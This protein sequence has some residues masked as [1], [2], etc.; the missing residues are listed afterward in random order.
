MY[1]VC[2]TESLGEIAHLGDDYCWAK[3]QG[4]K[5]L[6][7]EVAKETKKQIQRR[8]FGM[9]VYCPTPWVLDNYFLH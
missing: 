7:T 6:R 9:Q 3:A 8:T 1:H 4:G 2:E 5:V